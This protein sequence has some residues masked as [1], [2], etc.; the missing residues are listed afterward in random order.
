MIDFR[1]EK[2][3]PAGAYGNDIPLIFDVIRY[4]DGLAYNNTTG[5]F[6]APF[7]GIYTFN[8]R[9]DA[10]IG[11]KVSVYLNGQPYEI[12]ADVISN[13][14]AVYRSITM[15]LSKNDIVK[16]LVNTGIGTQTGTGS[17]SGFKVY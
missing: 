8:V 5:E 6:I 12:V 2:T 15:K 9:Y 16:V 7:D 11:A 13:S 1:A 14:G 10:L 4:N 17:F 3:N